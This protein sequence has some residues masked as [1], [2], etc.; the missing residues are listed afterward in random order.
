MNNLNIAAMN[1]LSA[2]SM[3]YFILLLIGSSLQKAQDFEAIE[4]QK[5]PIDL[6]Q[7]ANLRWD[8]FPHQFCE[9]FKEFQSVFEQSAIK[10]LFHT[11]EKYDEVESQV[12]KYITRDE[13]AEYKQEI[14][15]LARKCSVTEGYVAMY[16]FMYEFGLLR[17]CTTI[18]A[19]DGQKTAMFSNLDY[20][21]FDYFSKILFHGMWYDRG[22]KVLE[23]R[24]LFGFLGF[25]T[26]TTHEASGTLN[27][28]AW[29]QTGTLTNFLQDLENGSLKSTLWTLR[30]IYL[31]THSYDEIYS[32][33]LAI[34]NMAPSYISLTDHLSSRG[35]VITRNYEGTESVETLD[36]SI[37]KWYLVQGNLDRDTTVKDVRR[38]S[39]QETLNT[40]DAKDPNF[41]D[42]VFSQ[43]MSTEPVFNIGYSFRTISTSLHVSSSLDKSE[44][45]P[46]LA[47]KTWKPLASNNSNSAKNSNSKSTKSN[48]DLTVDL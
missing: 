17:G 3:V 37:G 16:N 26:A 6:R 42:K 23:T 27:A 22:H 33:I 39:A 8:S 40:L 41:S 5:I 30:N 32:K 43:I 10:K 48:L 34:E 14:L 46:S 44:T 13:L 36:L 9:Q 18:L 25:I 28:R 7:P 4:V 2:Y 29:D 47:I 12:L 35:S 38:L 11:K 19:T 45:Q 15:G 20:D 1:L 24:S 31:T 21:Y